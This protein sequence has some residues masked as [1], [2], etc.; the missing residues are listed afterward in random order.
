MKT[1]LL[2]SSVR[3]RIAK[4]KLLGANRKDEAKVT[5]CN[6]I[7]FE[8]N[9]F[10]SNEVRGFLIGNVRKHSLLKQIYVSG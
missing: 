8:I 3:G 5:V 1:A 7:D 4:L 6:E 10:P 9:R 2:S